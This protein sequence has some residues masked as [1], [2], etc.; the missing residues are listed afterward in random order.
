M[1]PRA[2]EPA[3]AP[4]SRLPI[5]IFPRIPPGVPPTKQIRLPKGGVLPK[6]NVPGPTIAARAAIV[7]LWLDA[8][9]KHAHNLISVEAGYGAAVRGAHPRARLGVADVGDAEA[10]RF[11]RA[12][13]PCGHVGGE[14]G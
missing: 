10:G 6:P 11:E 4:P 13:G 14:G 7:G 5:L 3:G 9:S 2:G 1:R 12:Q 8:P